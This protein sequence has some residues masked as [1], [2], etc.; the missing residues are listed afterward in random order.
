[1]AKKPTRYLTERISIGTFNLLGR[2]LSD[3][4]R[5]Q[6]ATYV[7]Q[8]LEQ[9][10]SAANVSRILCAADAEDPGVCMQP[11]PR[12]PQPARGEA[13][14]EPPT[15]YY[16]DERSIKLSAPRDS[17]ARQAVARAASTLE[18]PASTSTE[19][20]NPLDYTPRAFPGVRG[21]DGPAPGVEERLVATGIASKPEC[22]CKQVPHGSKPPQGPASPPPAAASP[23]A[24]SP[25]PAT[26]P[27]PTPKKPLVRGIIHVYLGDRVEN[28]EPTA[29]RI[30]WAPE[31]ELNAHFVILGGSGSGKSELVK[32][33]IGGI[34]GARVPVIVFDFH[35]ALEVAGL[36][37]IKLSGSSVDKVGINPLELYSR[38]IEEGGP[39]RQKDALVEAV[40]RAVSTLGNVQKADLAEAIMT[41]Y[42]EAGITDDPETWGAPA[43]NLK[44]VV[45]IISRWLQDRSRRVAWP[46]LRGLL[47]SVRATFGSGVFE[48][49]PYL[50][51]EQLL[52]GGTR[53]LMRSLPRAAQVIV[54]D[55][56]LRQ[57][58]AAIKTHGLSRGPASVRLMVVIDEASIVTGSEILNV[59]AQEA[60]KFGIGLILA[61]Q[62]ANHIDQPIRDNAGALVILRTPSAKEAQVN[63]RELPVPPGM[64]DIQAR[65]IL[66]LNRPGAGFVRTLAG[67]RRIQ[68]R[69]IDFP[70]RLRGAPEPPRAADLPMR[71]SPGAATD[72]TKEPSKP[73]E[74]GEPRQRGG[75]ERRSR[76]PKSQEDL[77]EG[78]PPPAPQQEIIEAELVSELEPGV[79]PAPATAQPEAFDL[80][81][82]EFRRLP[83]ARRVPAS[84]VLAIEP[85]QETSE[86]LQ[87]FTRRELQLAA[88]VSS[89]PRS[90]TKAEVAQRL[91][92]TWQTRGALSGESVETL[93][94]RPGSYLKRLAA[95]AGL[96]QAGTKYAQAVA[97]INWRDQ[98]R[99]DGREEVS[100]AKWLASVLMAL[101]AGRSVPE[102]VRADIISRGEAWI[103]AGDEADT[104]DAQQPQVAAT[105]SQRPLALP[106]HRETSEALINSE[107]DAGAAAEQSPSEPGNA[108]NLG[109]R[110][111]QQPQEDREDRLAR[112]YA[113]EY[114]QAKLTKQLA[115]EML[116]QEQRYECR[117]RFQPGDGS[118]R[119]ARLENDLDDG[120][121][122]I[123]ALRRA[124]EL[125]AERDGGK[126]TP[127]EEDRVFDAALFSQFE[128]SGPDGLVES[129]GPAKFAVH[130]R[131][132]GF[133]TIYKT[134]GEARQWAERWVAAR[135]EARGETAA[136]VPPESAGATELAAEGETRPESEQDVAKQTRRL[137]SST[138][139]LLLSILAS[140][141]SGLGIATPAQRTLAER[142]SQLGFVSLGPSSGRVQDS[143]LGVAVSEVA[144]TD[145]EVDAI[146]RVAIVD[147]NTTA[148]AKAGLADRAPV[149]A[150]PEPT[151]HALLPSQAATFPPEIPLQAPT[152][153]EAI[154]TP[155]TRVSF[156]N[157]EEW[158]RGYHAIFR[159]AATLNRYAQLN[160]HML[161]LPDDLVL[162]ASPDEIEQFEVIVRNNRGPKGANTA[163]W[164]THELDLISRVKQA[165]GPLVEGP[166]ALTRSAREQ[167]QYA[168][169]RVWIS[170]RA[171]KNGGPPTKARIIAWAPRWAAKLKEYAHDPV[172]A[173]FW[174]GVRDFL[175]EAQGTLSPQEET[176]PLLSVTPADQRKATL[177]FAERAAK[178]RQLAESTKKQIEALRDS[179]TS[180]QRPTR[181]R[182]GILE[183]LLNRADSL[184]KVYYALLGIAERLEAGCITP[185]L[186]E[187]DLGET[188]CLP[189]SL[190]GI[191]TRVIVE[192]LLRTDRYPTAGIRKHWIGELLEAAASKPN[193][194]GFVERVRQIETRCGEWW[195]GAQDTRDIAAIE[196]LAANLVTDPKKKSSASRALE[197][198]PPFKR[199]I[200]A[201]LTSPEEW[202]QARADLWAIVNRRAKPDRPPIEREIRN[203]ERELI[204]GNIPGY[205][206]TPPSL[207][208]LLVEKAGIL[209][210]MAVL[211]PEAG[212]GDIASAI[213]EVGV[214]PDVIE[215]NHT[216]RR[217]LELKGFK[218][219]GS[220]FLEHQDSYDRIV[221]NPPFERHQD[222]E[223]VR[224]AYSLLRPGGRVVA[225][226][227]IN[228]TSG[229]SRVEASFRDWLAE[230]Q[231]TWERL[232]EGSFRSSDQTTGVTTVVVVID[233]PEEN[234]ILGDSNKTVLSDSDSAEQETAKAG[235]PE[236]DKTSIATEAP[237]ERAQAEHSP[238]DDAQPHWLHLTK[239]SP[240]DADV[241]KSRRGRAEL[242]IRSR[243]SSR[244]WI[245]E[246][247]LDGRLYALPPEYFRHLD[248]SRPLPRHGERFLTLGQM[249]QFLWEFAGRLL[250]GEF[251]PGQTKAPSSAAA[252][253]PSD[254]PF[255]QSQPSRP[256]SEHDV[257][258]QIRRLTPDLAALLL[259]VASAPLPGY[260]P[261]LSEVDTRGRRQADRL[262]SKLQALGFVE[263]QA[264]GGRATLAVPLSPSELGQVMAVA[265]SLAGSQPQP[266]AT[267]DLVHANQQRKQAEEDEN[268]A[269]S[270]L[271][272][273]APSWDRLRALDLIR[274][275]EE[276]RKR[277]DEVLGAV[278]RTLEIR[279]PDLV[280]LRDEILEDFAS[281]RQGNAQPSDSRGQDS[282]CP[283]DNLACRLNLI[284]GICG[285][286]ANLVLQ[287]ASGEPETQIA[288]YCLIDAN[289]IIT[290]HDSMTFRE[291]DDYPKGIQE[292]RYDADRNEQLKVHRI[293]GN[294]TPTLIINTSGDVTNGTPVLT[295]EGFALGGNG[296]SLAVQEYYRTKDPDNNRLKDYII[297]HSTEFGFSPAQV[298]ATT[299]PL[300]VRVLDTMT[301][302][303]PE[304][305][306]RQRL[307]RLVRLL[308]VPLTK[309]L[310]PVTNAVALARQLDERVIDVL[311]VA[312][313]GD[314]TLAEYLSSRASK[315]LTEQLLRVQI[316]TPQNVSKYI[317]DQTGTYSE[318]GKRLLEKVFASAVLPE[319]QQLE[320][321]G[322]AFQET[323]ARGAPWILAAAGAGPSW[324]LRP[325]MIDAA[326]DLIKIRRDGKRS[327]DEALAQGAL[328]AGERLKSQDHPGGLTLL[329]TIFALSSSPLK[330]AR[331]A[332]SYAED[333][334]R[335]LSGT[336]ALFAS[337]APSPERALEHAM[338]VVVPKDKNS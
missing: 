259:R 305:E 72:P 300:V 6:A 257:A 88:L 218:L 77:D 4:T 260:D 215:I 284:G 231:S 31:Q 192:E 16:P 258:K 85:N 311:A 280:G 120:A 116:D 250:R 156:R 83:G 293:A 149:P 166:P 23:A 245:G 2:P 177:N 226:M 5:A 264:S 204:G 307:R 233:K 288:R 134:R 25:P 113:D 201:G 160:A 285:R 189:A 287:S 197:D 301:A 131:G 47:A 190:Q 206:N 148:A 10:V 153:G 186:A 27:R 271:S 87:R 277:G 147:A 310:D 336:G 175:L 297:E 298:R 138:A 98:A 331:F 234:E 194:Q 127:E 196:A 187:I 70:G 97:L 152:E 216:L 142:L 199:A 43:P 82:D 141:A 20:K 261:S 158:V 39:V 101:R 238:D 40:Q 132:R 60:R 237:G 320:A 322:P 252:E 92:Q 37:P 229:G 55:A 325:L 289:K 211:E 167:Q 3:E 93:E 102:R 50:P 126:T 58:F 319:A 182:A 235:E 330:F 217:I 143:A 276:S 236:A 165:N 130:F 118:A 299:R 239:D 326:R 212:K 247:Y 267:A 164:T 133:P 335:E 32:V 52:T 67:V 172:R 275:L 150:R 154:V 292:R 176:N 184:E 243:V 161:A 36:V 338:Q 171:G 64:P 62:S 15:D 337:E 19:K 208:R 51:L 59:L 22:E 314:T 279:R 90:G 84:S 123:R 168:A 290:S 99:E 49:K 115:R 281:G 124:L 137:S 1:M 136:S 68:V 159:R 61:S 309:E 248:L 162:A 317:N 295:E 173:A 294:L 249:R 262:L 91:V 228:W 265:G 244:G 256:E 242:T 254:T 219:V 157:L 7:R 223:H 119:K 274:F 69:P 33:L 278:R 213:R 139:R 241:Y 169:G 185:A 202:K 302:D 198:L 253:L 96:Y 76:Q 117:R 183:N 263:R 34:Q 286:P 30:W 125:Q 104:A 29:E 272:S 170:R 21:P 146:G 224:H 122:H 78:E 268:I 45:E 318:E 225:I 140:G 315:A 89:S 111:S 334:R 188:N 13:S 273:F 270:V 178:L 266:R 53:L 41:A 283:P 57:A 81:Y 95:M 230:H 214:E 203:A 155:G 94:K 121:R 144:L 269:G 106:P 306:K 80:T 54:V 48:R 291:R 209:P 71:Q 221:M 18:S 328:F 109:D 128:N 332:R 227:S 46:S 193:L 163:A 220:N 112:V 24:A 240:Y 180:R 327:V 11:L 246:V 296:R 65:D 329:R 191:D 308:N 181:R 79:D 74:L 129:Y 210:G 66:S 316:F 195:C 42:A 145:S 174:R 222:I 333:A 312:L 323:L 103:L 135:R 100:K 9:H 56:I 12:A 17:V 179:G 304:A 114:D 107:P 110:G 73:S 8:L 44:N 313:E 108:P 26:A 321:L 86:T 200:A 63:A 14:F 75:R 303:A 251:Q 105:V 255:A 207:A 28:G 205:H 35:D 38:E 324:D 232:P 282:T 151:E